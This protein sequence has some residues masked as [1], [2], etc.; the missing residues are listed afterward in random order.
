M[1]LWVIDLPSLTGRE[2][3][4]FPGEGGQDIEHDFDLSS[5]WTGMVITTDSVGDDSLA[6]DPIGIG[7]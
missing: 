3:V 4:A 6:M 5:G 2:Y 7:Q 1:T